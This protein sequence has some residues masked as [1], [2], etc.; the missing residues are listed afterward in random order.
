MAGT[1]ILIEKW[2]AGEEQQKRG[3]TGWE[4]SSATAQAEGVDPHEVVHAHLQGVY[5]EGHPKKEYPFAAP[6]RSADFTPEELREA[7]RKGK[8]KKAVGADG[9]SHEL[10]LAIGDDDE[11]L[12]LLLDWY[13]RLLHGEEEI[14]KD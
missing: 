4:A 8:T 9:V 7:L 13:N 6:C 3:A 5:V 1:F 2:T 12:G 10:L 11:G 14:P